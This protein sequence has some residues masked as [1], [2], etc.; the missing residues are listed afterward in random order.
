MATDARPLLADLDA[1]VA[2][3]LPV[4]E[5]LRRHPELSFQE[6]RIAGIVA[7]RLHHLG[8]DIPRALDVPSLFWISQTVV[9]ETPPSPVVDLCSHVGGRELG[10]SRRG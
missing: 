4:Y 1:L 10:G 5:D 7:D 2:S 6:E 3:H 8:C 9:T